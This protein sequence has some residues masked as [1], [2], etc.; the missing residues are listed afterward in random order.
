MIMTKLD[1]VSTVKFYNNILLLLSLLWLSPTQSDK[2]L[3]FNYVS[4]CSLNFVE[5]LTTTNRYP[6]VTA[7]VEFIYFVSLFINESSNFN[8]YLIYMTVNKDNKSVH[9]IDC[10]VFSI[11]YY[12]GF[13]TNNIKL[14]IPMFIET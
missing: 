14:R 10:R 1:T 11:Q 6:T 3:T 9:Y 2:R 7:T 5:C 12:Q 13:K 8:E 4:A